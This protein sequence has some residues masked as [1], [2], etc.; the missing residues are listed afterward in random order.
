M[1]AVSVVSSELVAL[2]VV[3]FVWDVVDPTARAVRTT[4]R[5]VAPGG[6]LS[7]RRPGPRS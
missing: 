1:N 7:T 5:F 2:V 4:R 6:Q 3:S